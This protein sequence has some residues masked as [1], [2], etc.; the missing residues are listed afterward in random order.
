MYLSLFYYKGIG[1]ML[2]FLVRTNNLLFLLDTL[3]SCV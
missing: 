2:V 3:V 1:G